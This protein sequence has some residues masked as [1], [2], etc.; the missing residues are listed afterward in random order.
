VKEDILRVMNKERRAFN[1][2]KNQA[3]KEGMEWRKRDKENK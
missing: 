3:Y 2:L 1:G